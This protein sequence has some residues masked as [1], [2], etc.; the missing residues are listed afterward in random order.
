MRLRLLVTE[1]CNRRCEGCCNKDWNLSALE[2]CK[3][4]K[5]YDQIIL[6]G[7]EPLLKPF[8]TLAIINRI[9][10]QTNV[11]IIVY[12]AKAG[13]DLDIL[14]NFI[15]GVTLTLHDQPDVRVF[16]QFL[17][18]IENRYQDKSLRL[19]IF[20]GIEYDENLI[21]PYWKIQSDMVWIKNCPLPDGEVF[22]RY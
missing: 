16:Y 19:N 12:T 9:K 10:E 22:M 5:G 17:E 11:P 20:K 1:K 8:N 3:I 2:K 14:L 6:T 7:G 18:R 15:D 13:K 4:F 21:P